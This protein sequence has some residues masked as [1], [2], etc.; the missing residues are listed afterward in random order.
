MV[1]IYSKHVKKNIHKKK[2]KKKKEKK[3]K[4]KIFNVWTLKI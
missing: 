1:L 2:K 3:K 4:N